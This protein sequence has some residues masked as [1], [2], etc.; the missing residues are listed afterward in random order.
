[1]RDKELKPVKTK[2]RNQKSMQLTTGHTEPKINSSLQVVEKTE[3][4]PGSSLVGVI[5]NNANE[6]ELQMIVQSP[7]ERA[8][9]N[10]EITSGFEPFKSELAAALERE[11]ANNRARHY[12][13][14]R[15]KHTHEIVF[16]HTEAKQC[17][18]FLVK[19]EHTKPVADASKAAKKDGQ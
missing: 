13:L 4:P 11:V 17:D 14:Y 19:G 3:L 5:Y 15:T 1:M 9:L 16:C 12:F 2:G 8:R 18:Y 7:I 10:F 6:G